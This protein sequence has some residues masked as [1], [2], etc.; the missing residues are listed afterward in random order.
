[1]HPEIDIKDLKIG[2]KVG[3]VKP[4]Q[5]FQYCYGIFDVVK[6]DKV[7][8]VLVQE[9][10]S[11]VFYFSGREADASS[12][13][14]SAKVVSVPEYNQIKSENDTLQTIREIRKNIEQLATV[15]TKLDVDSIRIYLDEY[16]EALAKL[17]KLET[18][19]KDNKSNRLAIGAEVHIINHENAG[20]EEFVYMSFSCDVI[21]DENDNEFDAYGVSQERIFFSL[22]GEEDLVNMVGKTGGRLFDVIDYELAYQS[23]Q[24]HQDDNEQAHQDSNVCETPKF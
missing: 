6:K 22:N 13:Y 23:E 9:T 12:I 15:N 4:A 11:R 14:T 10:N 8:V 24:T 1:M 19:S 20:E 21:T 18:S 7:K 3:V 16:V 2:E 5:G 17:N